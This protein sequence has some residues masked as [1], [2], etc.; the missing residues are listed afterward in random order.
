MNLSTN[1]GTKPLIVSHL[2]ESFAAVVKSLVLIINKTSN[3]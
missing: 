2:L 1:I 3:E